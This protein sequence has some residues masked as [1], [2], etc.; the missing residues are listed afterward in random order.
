MN[1]MQHI[2]PLL[3][4]YSSRCTV[5]ALAVGDS[6]FR[7][8]PNKG[9]LPGEQLTD[10]LQNENLKQISKKVGCEVLKYLYPVEFEILKKY[11]KLRHENRLLVSDNI[12]TSGSAFKMTVHRKT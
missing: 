8:M 6:A 9:M 1:N 10:T 4:I 12:A 3:L 5:K 11:Q 2:Q 7:N